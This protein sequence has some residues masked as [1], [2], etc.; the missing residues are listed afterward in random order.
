MRRLVVIGLALLVVGAAC[1]RPE[2]DPL[3]GDSLFLQTSAGVEVI[4][5]G[6]DSPS[7][8][9][10]VAVQSS[11]WSTVVETHL[12]KK[13]TTVV[14]VDPLTQRERWELEVPGNQTVNVVAQDGSLAALSPTWEYNHAVG[15]RTTRLTVVG[16]RSIEPKRFVLDGNYEPEAF[17]TDGKHL[18]LVSYLP[19]RAPNSYQVRRLD[20]TTGKVEGVTTPDKH[21]QQR[22]GG[23]ARIQTAS[24]DGRRLYTLYTMTMQ[25][26]TYAFIHVLSLDEL[27]AHCIDLPAEFASK[28]DDRA[29]AMSV[30]PDGK[31]LYVLNSVEGVVAEIDTQALRV[32]DTEGV[33]AGSG[34]AHLAHDGRSTLYVGS[35]NQLSS[36]CTTDGE[37]GRNWTLPEKI[38]G[39]QFT[40][41]GARLYV[42][43]RHELHVF[44]ATSGEK[45]DV[46][47]PSGI[48]KIVRFGPVMPQIDDGAFVCAC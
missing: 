31:S 10:P 15:R 20:L 29:S 8:S 38:R 37:R 9:D 42:G 48:A 32:V 28:A 21:L 35:G 27:W 3:A 40:T 7:Y 5:P 46:L 25:G 45:I 43:L 14:A 44:D 1:G 33:R 26:E 4:Q 39:L 34:T 16:S 23:T 47:N 12:G 22:M 6:A 36:I 11:D 18:F 17:S 19:A 13:S 30:S 2:G 24:P 41:D